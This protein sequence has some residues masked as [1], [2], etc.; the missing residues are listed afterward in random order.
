MSDGYSM[1]IDQFIDALW[2]ERG[3]SAN[4]LAAYRR[5]LRQFADFLDERGIASLKAADAGALQGFLASRLKS[6][7]SNRSAA[8]FL[9]TLRGFYRYHLRENRIDRDP[10][11]FIDSPRLGRSLPKSI[12]EADVERLLAAPNVEDPIDF[13]DRTMLELLYACGLRV[14]ELTGLQVSQ[15]SLNQGV[16]RVVGKGDKERLIP[17]GE[18]ALS[19][20]QQF[21]AGPRQVL[22]KERM[23]EVL[24][25]SNRGGQMTRQTFWYRIKLHAKRAGIEAH[26]SPHTLRHAFATHLINHGADLRVVQMLLG[27]SDLTT[28]QIYTHVARHRMQQL[29]A[30]HHPRG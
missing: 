22:L 18:E 28:T 12:S 4:T 6:G 1:E 21:L 16:V 20:V 27:H 15:L 25:P 11:Q 10:T 30:Q 3:L 29:H 26:L 14:T 7:H 8:R 13:R 5:D 24:F 2:I 19:W 23:S 9:S 17:I